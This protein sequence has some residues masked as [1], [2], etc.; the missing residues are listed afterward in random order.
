M[1]TQDRPSPLTPRLENLA[2]ITA[3]DVLLA[4]L[5]T[6][7]A[8]YCQLA[9]V[10]KALS[11]NLDRRRRR[12]ALEIAFGSRPGRHPSAHALCVDRSRP[13]GRLRPLRRLD[14]PGVVGAVLRSRFRRWRLVSTRTALQT[15]D[16]LSRKENLEL[17]TLGRVYGFVAPGGAPN[18]RAGRGRFCCAALLAARFPECAAALEDAQRRR[19]QARRPG[20]GAPSRTGGTEAGLAE[21]RRDAL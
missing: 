3:E 12:G 11:V 19:L 1:E 13:Q 20:E 16:Y 6:S 2:A 18:R 9:K 10:Y 14:R 15:R 17:L 5:A 21:G 7:K 4:Y 8:K